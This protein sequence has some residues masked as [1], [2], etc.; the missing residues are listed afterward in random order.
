VI[1][2][3]NINRAGEMGQLLRVHSAL[4]Q[5][6]ISVPGSHIRRLKWLQSQLQRIG[7]PLPTSTGN[8][9]HGHIYPI[10][11]IHSYK[12][13]SLKKEHI[14]IIYTLIYIK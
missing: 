6:P 1:V 7:C 3:N 11:L 13:K 14:Y 2:K 12:N 10:I 4:A 5:D 9:S 8:C